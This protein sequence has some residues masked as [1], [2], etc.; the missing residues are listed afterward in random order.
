V[1]IGLPQVLIAQPMS[2]D[3]PKRDTMSLE[4]ATISNMWEIAEAQG[5]R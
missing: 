3:R 4:D 5:L 2:N 1:E